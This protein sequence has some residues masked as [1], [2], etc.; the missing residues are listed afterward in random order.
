MRV[1]QFR[2]QLHVSL[3]ESFQGYMLAVVSTFHLRNL[4]YQATILAH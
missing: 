4:A 1:C 2:F 3:A